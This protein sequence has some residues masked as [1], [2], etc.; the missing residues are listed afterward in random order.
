MK[1]KFTIKNWNKEANAKLIVASGIIG[2]ITAF[3]PQFLAVIHEAPI[4][5]TPLLDAWV[6]W[7]LK[8]ATIIL[9]FLAIFTKKE[10][11]PAE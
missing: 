5:I 1:N 3:T 11:A 7:I 2:S 9:A 8:L 4:Q 6:T 10:N